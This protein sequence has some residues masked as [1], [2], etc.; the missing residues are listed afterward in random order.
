MHRSRRV[1]SAPREMG[2]TASA[3][4]RG[5]VACNKWAP[6][7]AR[8]RVGE[9]SRGVGAPSLPSRRETAGPP[10]RGSRVAISSS[11]PLLSSRREPPQIDEPAHAQSVGEL[12]QSVAGGREEGARRAGPDSVLRAVTAN[13]RRSCPDGQKSPPARARLRPC[14]R[15]ITAPCSRPRAHSCRVG[16]LPP[17][18]HAS[19]P[20]VAGV[21]SGTARVPG[22]PSQ[23][24]AG[25][26]LLFF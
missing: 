19:G 2:L 26:V 16:V 8:Y 9:M 20:A 13:F 23:P 12:P 22:E 14:I 24:R 6:W 7:P 15:G 4:S 10:G 18:P 1:G 3:Q 17:F 21:R 5:G 11:R 25:C